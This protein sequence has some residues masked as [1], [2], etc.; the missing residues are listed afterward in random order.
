MSSNLST[1]K[2]NIQ[3]G[4]CFSRSQIPMKTLNKTTIFDLFFR[5]LSFDLFRKSTWSKTRFLSPN[6]IR[7]PIKIFDKMSKTI[8]CSDHKTQFFLFLSL[9]LFSHVNL[10]PICPNL[11]RLMRNT[12]QRNFVFDFKIQWIVKFFRLW[13]LL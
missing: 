12:C 2:L 7:N 10:R 6:K 5:I 11:I 4:F 3:L 1:W 8:Y 13:H 9:F